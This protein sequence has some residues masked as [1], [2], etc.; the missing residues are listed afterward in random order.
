MTDSMDRRHFLGAAATGLTAT[1]SPRIVHAGSHRANDTIVV[2]VMG[3]GGRG[4]DHTREFSA[5]PG[6]EVA[7]VCDV[8]ANRVGKA[9]DVLKSA[10][11][12]APKAVGDFRRILDDKSVDA[13]VVATCNHW[14]APAAILAC[15]AGKHVYVEKPCSH[16]PREGE[17]LVSAARKNSRVVQM[18]NQRRSWPKLIEGIEAV[19]AGVIGRAYLGQSFYI[20]TRP[21]IGHGRE[22]PVPEGLDF[23]LWQGPAPRRPYRENILH[24]NWHWFW[25]WGNGEL[26]NNGIHMIDL[27]RWGLGVDFP[28]R[29]TSSGGRYHFQDDQETPDTHCVAFDFEGRKTI[30]WEGLSCNE[31]R[32]GGPGSEV[33][34]YGDGG[35]LSISGGGYTIRDLKGTTIKTVAGAGGD[36]E[37]QS[38][39]LAAIRDGTK[40]NSEIGE[41]HKSTLLCHLGNIAH[42]TGRTLRCDPK[43]GHIL[44][45]VAASAYW[46]REYAKGW[47]PKG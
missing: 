19:R 46:S 11:K 27:C 32:P 40:A 17:L 1:L 44:D 29:V 22:L 23:E 30:T 26:G 13:I 3:T 7:Y 35:S 41:G 25:H 8:D 9:A 18:G 6:V 28:T 37:H 34:F 24:Y 2:A 16:N 5:L 12:G 42:R 14:H 21:T 36:S 43:D 39:F 10:G 31:F 15:E 33:V 4:M 47:E 20:A 45:D 38:N